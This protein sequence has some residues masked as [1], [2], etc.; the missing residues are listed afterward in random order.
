MMIASLPQML[1]QILGD[2]YRCPSS[3]LNFSLT[4]ELSD[5]EG[6]FSFGPDI[7]CY[8]RSSTGSRQSAAGPSLSD[9]SQSVTCHGTQVGLPFDPTEVIN[10]LRLEHYLKS[11]GGAE[12]G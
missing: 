3:Y 6:Y 10:N 7:T 2:Q 12:P 1:S 5:D 4:G 9:L 11:E 8:G